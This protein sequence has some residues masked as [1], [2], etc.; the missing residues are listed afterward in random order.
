MILSSCLPSIHHLSRKIYPSCSCSC[1][2]IKPTAQLT[3]DVYSSPS[4]CA[5]SSILTLAPLYLP[6]INVVPQSRAEVFLKLS[7]F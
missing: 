7:S 4:K 1:R 6:C 5:P 2:S 3:G